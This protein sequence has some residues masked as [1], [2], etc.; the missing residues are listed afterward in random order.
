MR[1]R[2]TS[3]QIVE[4]LRS[5]AASSQT[6]SSDELREAAA[7]AGL[8][9]DRVDEAVQS[10]HLRRRRRALMALGALGSV[11]LSGLLFWP[12]TPAVALHNE[13][14]DVHDLELLVP[15]DPTRC[16]RAPDPPAR[17]PCTGSRLRPG[18][19]FPI[20]EKKEKLSQGERSSVN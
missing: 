6:Y 7:E 17:L 20:A 8:G 11:A 13:S 2:Y 18:P 14:R 12:R 3:R 4:V 16:R 15:S 1:Q 10:F 5:A 19:H 9:A